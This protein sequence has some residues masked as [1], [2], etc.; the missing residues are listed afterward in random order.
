MSPATTKL[1]L[2]VLVAA[3]VVLSMTDLAAARRRDYTPNEAPQA[4]GAPWGPIAVAVG[5]AAVVALLGFLNAKRTHL[6]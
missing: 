3:L 2:L 4:E 6:D 1:L 5:F